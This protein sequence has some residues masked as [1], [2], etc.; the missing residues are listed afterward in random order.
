MEKNYT[1]YLLHFD[2]PLCHAKHY[3]GCTMDVEKRLEL[4]R[5]NP[6]PRILQVLKEKGI[7][8]QLVRTWNCKDKHFERRLK[9]RKEAPCL[10]PIC[11]PDTWNL[12]ANY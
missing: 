10:C 9:N 6:G 11:N 12:K 1:C 2:R 7:G 4:H 8:F 5:K 3:I